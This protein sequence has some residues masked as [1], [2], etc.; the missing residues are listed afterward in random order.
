MNNE[1]VTIFGGSG[2]I[3]RHIVRGLATRGALIRIAV[4]NPSR[5]KFL[6]PLGDVGQ[7]TFVKSNIIDKDSV[8]Q[9]IEE[10]DHVINL[11]GTFSNKGNENF[12]SIHIQSPKNISSACKKFGVKN[13]IHVTSIGVDQK[14]P[15]QY[16][17]SKAYGEEEVKKYFPDAIIHRP[18][19]I[20]G[21]QDKFFNL[22]ASIAQ[23]SPFMPIFGETF[24]SYG[25]TLYQPVYVQDVANGIINSLEKNRSKGKVFEIGG[26][27]VYSFQEIMEIVLKYSGKKRFLIPFPF[28]YAKI[29]AT[30][31][32]F[33]PINLITRD[34]VK[35]LTI[36]N[37]VGSK[38]LTLQDLGI[39]PTP[40]ESIVPSYLDKFKR[41]KRE[42]RF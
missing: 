26:P 3:G 4:R 14:S 6:Q 9:L 28:A 24:F 20:F 41:D 35:Q 37:I 21:P 30:L 13:L 10:S 16:F 18:S 29:L 38:S 42:R 7:I 19:L 40:L 22:F 2:F 34:Q 32:E 11:V 33:L 1:V 8:N 12:D 25:R 31:T 23:Y 27:T 36:D 15:S 39:T 5:A 17:K